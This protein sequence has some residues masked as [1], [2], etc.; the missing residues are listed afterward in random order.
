MGKLYT[1]NSHFEK[2]QIKFSYLNRELVLKHDFLTD[3]YHPTL[4]IDRF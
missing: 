2:N 3:N 1:S 4:E